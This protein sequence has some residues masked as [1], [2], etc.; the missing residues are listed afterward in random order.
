MSTTQ[1]SA[2]TGTTI[3]AQRE[4]HVGRVWWTVSEF[5]D[6]RGFMLTAR[7]L[8]TQFIA[9]FD[10]DEWAAFQALVVP[11]REQEP[12]FVV[13]DGA[14]GHK[15]PR[16]VETENKQ[17]H[18]VTCHGVTWAERPDGYWTLGPFFAEGA[19]R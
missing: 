13:F 12:V 9:H 10:A 6:G 4:M 18:G 1:S 11:S 3:T 2:P 17:G 5:D 7:S 14:P 8:G 19:G 16:F 15:S